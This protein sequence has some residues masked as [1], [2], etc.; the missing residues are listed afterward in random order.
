VTPVNSNA[1]VEMVAIACNLI[2]ILLNLQVKDELIEDQSSVETR[3]K[4]VSNF[5]SDWSDSGK[6]SW[7]STALIKV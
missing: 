3:Q 6:T 4:L 5:E 1:N 2:L 7:R